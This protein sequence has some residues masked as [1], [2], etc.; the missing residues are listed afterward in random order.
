ML[1]RILAI[2]MVVAMLAG[3]SAFAEPAVQEVSDQEAFLAGIVSLFRSFNPAGRDKM[4]LS[5]TAGG[6]QLFDAQLWGTEDLGALKISVPSQDFAAQLQVSS[7]AAYVEAM[8]QVVGVKFEDLRAIAEALPQA[9]LDASGLNVD[10]KAFAQL[11]TEL[12]KDLGTLFLKTVLLRNVTMSSSAEGMQFSF[13]ATGKELLANVAV[14]VDQVLAEEKYLPLLEQFWAVV[15]AYAAQQGSSEVPTLEQV[16]A[17]WPQL[18][19]QLAQVEV[20]FTVTADLNMASDYSFIDLTGEVAVSGVKYMMNWAWRADADAGKYSL[21]GKLTERRIRT[22]AEGEEQIRDYD[23]DINMDAYVKK[24]MGAMWNLSV[25]YPYAGFSLKLEGNHLGNAGNVNLELVN[26]RSRT[27]RL[28]GKLEYF[29]NEEGGNAKLTWTDARSSGATIEAKADKANFLLKVAVSNMGR[30]EQEYSLEA[31]A[32]EDNN[33]VYA[34]LITPAFSAIYDTAELLIEYNGV[35]VHCV[36][37][38]LSDHEYQITMTP[39]GGPAD[40]NP[41]YIRVTYDGQEGDWACKALVLDVT[42]EEALSID[43]VCAPTEPVE[44]LSEREDLFM[45]TPEV[46]PQLVKQLMNQAQGMGL[47]Y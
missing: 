21:V 44:L 42:G 36:G 34:A 40:S 23:I 12:L 17:M 32:D 33:L 18:K 19:E 38:F 22:T 47:G 28:T 24:G 37:E 14:F 43:L 4:N 13:S 29:V 2:L 39:E 11:D 16:I 27:G 5:V 10:L 46:V 30:V 31:R 8:G 6:A 45:I 41:A 15:S 1:K 3:V 7:E 9:I 35:K 26:Q 25:K 20:D